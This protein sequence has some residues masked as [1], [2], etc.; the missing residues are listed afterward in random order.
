MRLTWHDAA[1]TLLVATAAGLYW[2]F[3]TGVDV[4]LASGPR[5]LAVVLF[6]LGVGACASGGAGVASADTGGAEAVW[7][8]VFGL[9]GAAVFVLMLLVLITANETLLAVLVTLL[10]ALWLVATARH[11]V[12][13][14]DRG[15]HG[16]DRRSPLERT[17]R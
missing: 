11:L 3:R 4:P 5:V 12:M 8:R 10:V 1:A 16:A 13:P 9:H 15:G 14:A 6:G 17:A 7:V 2:A